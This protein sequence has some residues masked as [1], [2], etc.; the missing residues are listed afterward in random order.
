[1]Y[2]KRLYKNRIYQNKIN[3]IQIDYSKKCRKMFRHLFKDKC[4]HEIN[5]YILNYIGFN[6]IKINDYNLS[7]KPLYSSF[8]YLFHIKLNIQQDTENKENII[9]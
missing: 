6:Q 4:I 3:Y 5:E 8:D 7:L 9:I 1:M 2:P